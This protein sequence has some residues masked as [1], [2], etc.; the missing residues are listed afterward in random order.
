MAV[1]LRLRRT[2]APAKISFRIVAADSRSPRDGRFLEILGYYDPRRAD[3]K[4]NLERADHW[5]KNGALPSET[6]KSILDRARTGRKLK[7]AERKGMNPPPPPV[8]AAPA[9]APAAEAP[10]AEVAAEEAAKQE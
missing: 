1:H 5:I 3:E 7:P 10:V 6:V 8:P 4:I 9:E 2:G